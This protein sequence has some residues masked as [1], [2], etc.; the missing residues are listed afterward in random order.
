MK[1]SQKME[2]IT[3]QP[4]KY[5]KEEALPFVPDEKGA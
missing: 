1:P 4:P 5:T 2:K 3:W